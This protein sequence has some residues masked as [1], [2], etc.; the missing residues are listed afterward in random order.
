MQTI[1]NSVMLP[2][3]DVFRISVN[4]AVACS[5]V[6]QSWFSAACGHKAQKIVAESRSK[7]QAFWML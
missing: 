1:I 6:L 7:M 5:L 4:L 3:K 2:L